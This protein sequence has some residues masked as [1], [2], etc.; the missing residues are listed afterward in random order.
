MLGAR[1]T[2]K[3][4]AGGRRRPVTFPA[5]AGRSI[6]VWPITRVGAG[7]IFVA[8]PLP[9]TFCVERRTVLIGSSKRVDQCL[10]GTR[11]RS[12]ET[13]REGQ[14]SRQ[15]PTPSNRRTATLRL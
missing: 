12:R 7:D 5:D 10:R 2:I 9:G 4:G 3:D 13:T 11:F 1:C 15:R 8:R 14:K 6:D